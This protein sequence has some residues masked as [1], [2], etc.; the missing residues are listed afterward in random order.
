M[1]VLP[2]AA[3]LHERKALV[4]RLS[5]S[6]ARYRLIAELDR[7]RDHERRDRRHHPLRL[8]RERN[9][10]GFA[11]S[12]LIGRK[13]YDMIDAA[14]LAKH[15]AARDE[16]SANPE[17]TVTNTFRINTA[18][19]GERWYDTS[20]RATVDE[21]GVVTG[22]VSVLRDVT[23]RKAAEARLT[24]E[25]ST[26]PLTGL[27]NRRTVIRTLERG[28]GRVARGEG[29]CAVA[30]F[31]LDRFKSI[32]D[33]HGHA[34]GDQVLQAFA[35]T[36]TGAVRDADLVGRIGGEEFALVLWNADETLA[37]KICERLRKSLA[38]VRVITPD[39]AEVAV[40][41]SAGIAMVEPGADATGIL[42]AAD[43]ALY[44]AKAAGRD[45]LVLAA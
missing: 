5:E 34:V 33:S 12:K 29:V 40:R 9:L 42:A 39:G 26:D 19:G 17:R 2:V 24:L 22:F 31:D 30:V 3:L 16:A 1:L 4:Q 27:A 25:A 13:S 44:Q 43:A 14:E 21:D 36:A 10:V 45:R 6:E 35:A 20:Y 8:G 32:N 37:V 41:A 38:A 18:R 28:I 11:P 15:D 23:D 7:R